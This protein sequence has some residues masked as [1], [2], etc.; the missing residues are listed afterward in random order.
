MFPFNENLSVN[1]DNHLC[2]DGVDLVELAEEFGTPLFVFS[3]ETI[4]RRAEEVAAAFGREN[5]YYASK[6]NS[7]IS[8]LKL[9]R[10]LGLN[11]EVSSEGELFAA[12]KAGFKPEQIIFNGAAKTLRELQA[13]AE[14]GV[15]CVNLDSVCELERL[16]R[17]A[18]ERGV[19][20]NVAFRVSSGVVA[21]THASFETAASLSKFGVTLEEAVEVYREALKGDGVNPIG[22]HCHIAS[23]VPRVEVFE[24]GA[25]R[26]SRTVKIVEDTLGFKLSE[27]DMGG[28]IPVT[29][30]KEPI[31]GLPEYFYARIKPR[32][33]AERVRRVLDE[34]LGDIRLIAEPG[35]YVVGD[36]AVLLTQ[37]QNVKKK[38]K[39]FWVMIDAGFNV[40]L[41]AFSYKWYFHMVSASRA[42]EEHNHPYM[43]GGPLCDGGDILLAGGQH[44]M[45]P[46]DLK[47]GEYLALLD[48]GAYTLEQMSQFNGRPRPAALIVSKGK[49]KLIRR[50]ESLED[51][52]RNDCYDET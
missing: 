31:D 51:L 6:A 14:L 1:D 36:S 30:A 44:R 29:Y 45:L 34:V 3:E 5:V 7:N 33:V 49:V 22:V 32:E 48:A 10:S 25:Y 40:L 52:V 13:A 8:V 12:L 9:I 42:G 50:R 28:G 19:E 2:L 41:D 23:Q 15:H 37:V 46:R 4:R 20:V 39:D 24:E 38:G 47:V 17:V 35:R 21:G 26:V 43:V 27:F 18:R 11:V 16:R